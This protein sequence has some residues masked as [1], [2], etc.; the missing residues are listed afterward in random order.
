M[1]KKRKRGKVKG[2]RILK[3]N[4]ARAERIDKVT[5]AFASSNGW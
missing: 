4:T 1:K 2:K 5:Y 3:L